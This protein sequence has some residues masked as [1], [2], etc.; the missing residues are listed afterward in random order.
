[1][2]RIILNITTN[3]RAQIPMNIRKLLNITTGD[4]IMVEIIDVIH[5]VNENG[6]LM[7][8]NQ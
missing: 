2:T 4:Q 6:P 1:M 5:I 8:K 3:G 7:D